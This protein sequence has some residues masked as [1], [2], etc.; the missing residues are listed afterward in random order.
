MELLKREADSADKKVHIESVDEDILGRA[1]DAGFDASNPFLGRNNKT[2]SD[3]VVSSKKP[4]SSTKA[5]KKK[6]TKK[7]KEEREDEVEEDVVIKGQAK[8]TSGLRR[9]ITAAVVTA[10]IVGGGTFLLVSLPRVSVA[11]TFDKM[12]HGFIGNLRVS[13]SIEESSVDEEVVR[14]RGVVFSGEKNV[15]V[16]QEAT[17]TDE[18]GRKARGVITIYN[19]FGTEP[20]SL[21]ATTRFLTPDGKL[22]RLDSDIT[23]PGAVKGGDGALTPGTIDAAVTADQPGE[24]YNIGPVDRFSIPGFQ[25]SAKY[26]GFYGVSESSMKGG[27]LGESKVPTD[28]DI[29]SARAKAQSMIEDA[30]KTEFFIDLPE[31]ITILDD[32]YKT[33]IVREE[34]DSEIDQNGT[35]GLSLYGE[36]KLI[37]FSEAELIDT[38]KDLFEEEEGV[39]LQIHEYTVDYGEV[40]LDIENEVLESA[41]SV[42][43]G[44]T[45]PFDKDEFIQ[46]VLGLNENEL[47]EQVFSIPGVRSGQVDLWPFWVRKVPADPSKVSVDAN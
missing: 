16:R 2:V 25:G 21:V 1:S 41:I 33:D 32:S 35:F 27:A 42:E 43:S 18:T 15:T 30:L 17:G 28:D 47:K 45:R 9:F 3:I 29:E 36:L 24:E 19:D 38:L 5:S 13:P 26:D 40:T 31:G 39:T 37:G 20:Q 11:L 8:N 46:S 23:V 44:W 4:K 10:A 22:Y 14:L 34:I 12:E 7:K 6:S